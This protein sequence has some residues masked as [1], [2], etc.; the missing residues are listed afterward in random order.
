[1]AHAI[2][3]SAPEAPAMARRAGRAGPSKCVINGVATTAIEVFAIPFLSSSLRAMVDSSATAFSTVAPGA[4]RPT[5]YI[6]RTLSEPVSAGPSAVQTSAPA[7]IRNSSDMTPITSKA[8]A[9]LPVPTVSSRPTI[10]GS[11]EKC[12]RHT[13][14]LNTTVGRAPTRS[15]AGRK[16]RPS[17]GRAPS[18][19]KNPDDTAFCAARKGCSGPVMWSSPQLTDPNSSI[20]VKLFWPASQAR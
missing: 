19:S 8:A 15:S 6:A 13:F 1:M 20:A 18:T 4:R 2:S 12:R 3:S 7:G 5:A 9:F 14:A 16:V 11:D 10:E 17:I